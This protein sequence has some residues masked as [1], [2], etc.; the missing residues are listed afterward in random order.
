MFKNQFVGL[1]TSIDCDSTC[2]SQKVVAFITHFEGPRRCQI[3]KG[4]EGLRLGI[5]CDRAKWIQVMFALM[6]RVKGPIF[7]CVPAKHIAT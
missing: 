5:D 1:R 2:G 3:S 7:R 4:F 6:T